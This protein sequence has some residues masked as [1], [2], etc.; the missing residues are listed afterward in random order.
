ML[1]WWRGT[2]GSC[3]AWRVPPPSRRVS[4]PRHLPRWGRIGGDYQQ[5]APSSAELLQA[6]LDQH[7]DLGLI[8]K[9]QGRVFD[10]PARVDLSHAQTH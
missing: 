4:A 1:A 3:G 10:H 9:P 2:A 8:T 6:R 7:T 5:R